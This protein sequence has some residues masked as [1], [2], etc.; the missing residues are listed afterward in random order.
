MK[1][2]YKWVF[3]II[4]FSFFT[5]PVYANPL[6]IKFEQATQAY[7]EGNYSRAIELF[8][9]AIEMHPQFAPSYNFLGLAHKANG[10]D[11]EKVIWYFEKAIEIDPNYAE[12]Y[13]NAAKSFY[14][15]GDFETAKV[16]GLKAIELSP[17]NISAKLSLGW[18]YL[19]GLEE[20]GYAIDYFED[21]VKESDIPYANFGLGLAYFM[22]NQRVKVME[23]ITALRQMDEENFASQLENMIRDNTYRPPPKGFSPS[24]VAKKRKASQIVADP[25]APAENYEKAA[26]IPV[27]LRSQQRELTESLNSNA[28]AQQQTLSGAERIRALQQ[29]SSQPATTTAQQKGSFY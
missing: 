25:P 20:P 1:K 27:R 4:F 3:C 23:M 14:T 11:I 22:D 12:A 18:V 19:L 13:E 8:N 28:P 24:A 15:Q 29:R 9:Q 26:E 17:D 21:V 5:L 6:K 16:R 2:I 7:N 10:S